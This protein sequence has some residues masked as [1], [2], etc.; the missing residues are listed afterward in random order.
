MTSRTAGIL[1]SPT[2]N[3]IIASRTLAPQCPRSSGRLSHMA[4]DFATVGVIG[5]GTMGAAIAEV[6]ARNGMDV[7]AVEVSPEAAERGQ[8]ALRY[9][10][11]RAVSVSYT[12]LRA[13]ET[14]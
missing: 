11:D 7:V 14:V 5:L 6:F 9:S 12:H 3:V 8:A 13:H 10:T 2:Q 1:P 4:H